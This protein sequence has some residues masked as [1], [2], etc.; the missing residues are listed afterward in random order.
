MNGEREAPTERATATA[1]VTGS[2]RGIGAAIARRLAS[3]GASIVVSGRTSEDG[4]AVVES[5]EEEGGDAIFHRTDVR[6]PGEIESLVETAEREFGGLDVLVNNAAFE[7]DT[8]P[9]EVDLETWDAL[10]ETDFRAYWLAAK[11]AYPALADSD[12]GAIVNVG[13]NHAIATHPRKFPY[14]AIKAG[15]DGMTRSMAVAWGTDGIRVNSVNP[16]W[17]MVERIAADLSDEQLDYLDRIHPIGRI[18][19]PE[20]VANAVAFL[21]SEEAGFVTGA[22]LAVDGGRTAVLQDD[23]YLDDLDG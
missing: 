21:A 19:T 5:I 22:C 3:D 7:T 1:I 2:T 14:N 20:D 13:S 18:G 9:D 6:E 15:I 23:L 10:L 12:R 16:G 11:Y 17:T 4:D 8:K